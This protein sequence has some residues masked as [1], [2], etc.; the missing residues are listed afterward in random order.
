MPNGKIAVYNSQ[1]IGTTSGVLAIDNLVA[2]NIKSGV[3]V[4]GVV[5][6][7]PAPLGNMADYTW[8]QI[9]EYIDNGS[10]P[11]K[12]VGQTKE[13]TEGIYAGYH[14]Q[15]V[16]LFS[17]RYEKTDGTGYTKAV[18]MFVEVPSQIYNINSTNTNSRVHCCS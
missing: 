7:A 6:T 4:G 13:I 16:D 8:A 18:F 14:I 10:A 1:A 17:G 9:K 11:M 5:G 12:W 15:C 2:E 3:N